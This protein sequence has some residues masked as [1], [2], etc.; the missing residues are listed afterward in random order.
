MKNSLPLLNF[1]ELMVHHLSAVLP[2]TAGPRP[3]NH[4]EGI[5]LSL[6]TRNCKAD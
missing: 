5:Q 6:S 2:D 3:C 4:Q 1:H